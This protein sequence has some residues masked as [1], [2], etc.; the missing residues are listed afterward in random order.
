VEGKDVIIVDDMI[1]SGESMQDVAAELK[2]RKAKKVFIFSTFGLFTNGLKGFDQFYEDGLIDRILTTNLVYQSPELL[3]RPYYTS[4]DMSKYIALIIDNL[5]H[6]A[7]LSDLLNPTR[8]IN[9]L[10]KRHRED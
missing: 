5:N 1:S 2:R 7:S 10:L 8:R 6:D 9:R 3:S 4:V